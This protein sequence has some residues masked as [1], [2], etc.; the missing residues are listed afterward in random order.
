MANIR[1]TCVLYRDGAN[2]KNKQNC[3]KTLVICKARHGINKL[4]P[5]QDEPGLWYVLQALVVAPEAEWVR[6]PRLVDHQL[7]LAP[8]PVKYVWLSLETINMLWESY[9]CMNFECGCV[10]G[11]V[12]GSQLRQKCVVGKTGEP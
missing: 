1:I 7:Q 10:I 6:R 11:C 5:L 12:C 2:F 4:V 8:L 9:E 3:S